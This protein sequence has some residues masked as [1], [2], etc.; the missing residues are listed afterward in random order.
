MNS[1]VRHFG[2]RRFGPPLEPRERRG[3]GQGSGVIV[4]S[5]GYIL[6]NNHVIDG[7]KTVTVTL[8]DK[9]EFK[10]R[11][12]GSDPKSDIA[13]IKIDGSNLPTHFLG[14]LQPSSSRGICAGGRKSLRPEFHR[15]LRNCECLR[16][17]AHGHHAV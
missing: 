8:P 1:L 11:I 16:A 6:T 9:R 10:G 5:D 2:P 17:R 15:H 13:V 7:A 14:R 3:G 4:S 12:V